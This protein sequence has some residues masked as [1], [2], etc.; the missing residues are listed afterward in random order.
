L[1]NIGKFAKIASG[2]GIKEALLLFSCEKPPNT[3]WVRM[4]TTVSEPI[5]STRV[6][7]LPVDMLCKVMQFAN[8]KS[9]VRFAGTSVDMQSQLKSKIRHASALRIQRFWRWCRLFSTNRVLVTRF[10]RLGLTPEA[11]RATR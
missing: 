10:L 1:L 11:M 3:H 5:M 2:L 7:D 4:Q 8:L 6:G 9:F